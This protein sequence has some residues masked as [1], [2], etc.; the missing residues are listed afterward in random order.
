MELLL[1]I[2]RQV[3]EQKQVALKFNTFIIKYKYAYKLEIKF[4]R[5]ELE[6]SIMPHYC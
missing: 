5:I 4:I 1:A 6:A 2:N 3:G